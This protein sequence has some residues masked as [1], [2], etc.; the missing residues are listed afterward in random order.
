MDEIKLNRDQV[1][2][3]SL[4]RIQFVFTP[5]AEKRLIIKRETFNQLPIHLSAV[6]S[7][8]FSSEKSPEIAFSH[9]KT[10]RSRKIQ[11][12]REKSRTIVG[13]SSNFN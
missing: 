7:C 8:N 5:R 1:L 13:L 12:T 11:T 9:D 2:N 10:I 6:S 4:N 3:E